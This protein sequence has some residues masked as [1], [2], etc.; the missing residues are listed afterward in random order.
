MI[1]AIV[2]AIRRTEGDGAAVTVL[3]PTGKASDRV[4]ATLSER[5]IERVETSTVHSFLARN[6]W[7]NDNL[8]FKRQWG[9]RAGSGTLVVDE[10]SMLDLGLMAALVRALDWRQIKRLIL[11]GDANQLPPIGRGRVFSDV[12]EWLSQGEETQV[13][14]LG[15][16]LR[17]LQ[18]R[19]NDRGTAILEVAGL[20]MQANAEHNGAQTSPDDEELIARVHAGGDVDK[21]LHVAYWDDGTTLANMLVRTIER[22]MEMR[23]GTTLDSSRPYELWRLAFEDNPATYQVLTPH[24]GELHGVEALNGA[25]QGRIAPGLIA[26]YGALDGITLRDKVIQ[27]R[28]RSRSNPIWAF[29]YDTRRTERV[30]VFNGELG[31]VSRHNFDRQ[32]QRFRLKRFQ[33]KFERKDKLAVG[34]GRDLKTVGG[35]ERVKDNLELA[36]AISIHKAQGSEF[37]HTYVMI[38]RSGGRSLSPELVYTAMTRATR[39]C[40]L[41]VEGDVST[42]LSARRP[43]NAQRRL[44][45]SSLFGGEIRAC[46]RR[47]AQ[48]QGLVR[49]REDSQ[50]VERG[51]G[52]VEVQ[53]W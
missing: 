33:V 29:N 47:V 34:Y 35:S 46:P 39:H 53:S 9:R 5:E 36:Y 49:R 14:Y 31:F 27:Y 44:V 22:D 15:D 43:E 37:A 8:T 30:E 48:T 45:N 26:R 24:R 19:V 2:R 17:Q 18:N 20:F 23:T 11:V 13:A 41:L 42:L 28:N 12:I 40:T 50:G 32:R 25:I 7:L 38:P 10:A 4:R 1:C 21:D 51:N 6:G 52:A 16:N 3:A